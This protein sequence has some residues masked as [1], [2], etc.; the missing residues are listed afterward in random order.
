[1]VEDSFGLWWRTWM[2]QVW[3]SLVPTKKWRTSERNLE[4]GDIVQVRYVSKLVKPVFRM[5]RVSEVFPDEHGKVRDVIVDTVAKKKKDVP[6]IYKPGKLDHQRI[7]VQ[8]V[9][10]LIPASDLHQLPPADESLHVCDES[11]RIPDL[12]NIAARDRSDPGQLSSE[13]GSPALSP[14]TPVYLNTLVASISTVQSSSY[15]C[16]DCVQHYG[17]VE[18]QDWKRVAVEILAQPQ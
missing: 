16:S 13:A 14:D 6:G 11:I 18:H 2:V 10:V 8:R 5:G 9:S 15:S 3:D 12:L 4:V 1:M 7:P 17:V